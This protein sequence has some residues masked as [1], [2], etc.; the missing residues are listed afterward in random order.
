VTAVFIVIAYR[1]YTKH[2]KVLRLRVARS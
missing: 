1:F 2:V